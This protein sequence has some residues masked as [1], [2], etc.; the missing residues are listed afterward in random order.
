MYQGS[1][2]VLGL[3][4]L[5]YVPT[6]ILL[7]ISMGIYNSKTHLSGVCQ[8]LYCRKPSSPLSSQ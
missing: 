2:V 4:F 5:L 1:R 8:P 6:I 3:L 7:S